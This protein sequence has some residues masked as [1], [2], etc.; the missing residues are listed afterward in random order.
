MSYYILYTVKETIQ[1]RFGRLQKTKDEI[2]FRDEEN[3]NY[4]H[5]VGNHSKK[6]GADEKDKEEVNKSSQLNQDG[7]FSADVEIN[8]SVVCSKQCFRCGK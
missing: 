1:I 4:G 5:E 2:A 8:Q 6:D 3:L 7:M